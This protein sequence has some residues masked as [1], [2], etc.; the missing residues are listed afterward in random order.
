[1]DTVPSL[2][3]L[4]IARDAHGPNGDFLQARSSSLCIFSSRA[5]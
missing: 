4:L 3:A 2:L 1:M 5:A